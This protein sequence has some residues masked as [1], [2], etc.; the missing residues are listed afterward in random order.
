MADESLDTASTLFFGQ[1]IIFTVRP[2]N[3]VK[4]VCVH[5]CVPELGDISTP[6]TRQNCL[7]GTS[8]YVQLTTLGVGK[9]LHAGSIQR[10]TP[11]TS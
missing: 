8:R 7:A 2:K 9:T 6:G 5:L 1:Y 11:R 3:G 4:M 10:G